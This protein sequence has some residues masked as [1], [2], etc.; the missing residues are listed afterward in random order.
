MPHEVS[1]KA[2][3]PH[4][5]RNVLD[6][7]I[8][9]AGP[10]G[11]SAALVLGRMRRSVMVF[12]SGEYTNISSFRPSASST[13]DG[14]SSFASRDEIMAELKANYKT[15]SLAGTAAKSV[16]ERGVVFEVEELA[17]RRWKG[18]KVILAMENHDILPE[19][20]GFSDAWGRNIFDCLQ[21]HEL[22]GSGNTRAAVLLTSDS[23]ESVDAC[24]RSAHLCRQFAQDIT[25]LTHGL[26]HIGQHTAIMAAKMYGFKLDSRPIDAF[27]VDSSRASVTVEFSDGSSNSYGFIAYRPRTVVRGP[28]AQQLGLD[29]KSAGQILI[30]DEFQETSK[31]GVFAAGNCAT[32]LKDRVIGVGN[33]ITAGIGSNLQIVEDDMDL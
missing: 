10:A 22:D 26:H 24:V 25:I 3:E 17:G 33:G 15:V 4:F 27:N 21:C 28:F 11:L 19:I 2:F 32:G 16:R 7:L 29:M 9:G 12:D 13:H 14:E 6:V 31:R 18:R 5:L 1:T 23:E 20:P 8:I 30:E